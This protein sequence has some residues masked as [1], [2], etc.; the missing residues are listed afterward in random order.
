MNRLRGRRQTGVIGLKLADPQ[1]DA[2][3]IPELQQLAD[4]W[5]DRQ[6]ELA[7]MLIRRWVG[8]VEKYA[9]V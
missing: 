9:Q 7:R 8:D 5:L 3:L 6:P 4:D 1:R 2:P